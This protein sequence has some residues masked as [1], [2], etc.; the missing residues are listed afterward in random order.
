MDQAF[1]EKVVRTV[2][3]RIGDAD[4]SV[5]ELA[6]A[7]AMS[8]S[9]I[10]R[11]LRALISHS[12]G[13][14]IRSIRLQRAADLLAANAGNVAEIGYQVGFNDQSHFSRTFKRHYG[15][16]PVDYRREAG[17]RPGA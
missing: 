11:K 6:D 10:T 1:F 13:Q 9:Q 2:E 16:T 8:T 3:E 7:M 14:L 17:R 4:F 15:K 12:P 5:Q